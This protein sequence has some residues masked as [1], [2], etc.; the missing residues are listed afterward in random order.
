MTLP[1]KWFI[2][3]APRLAR[4]PYSGVGCEPGVSPV[5]IVARPSRARLALA[6]VN[7]VAAPLD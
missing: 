1:S 4:K 3:M 2:S 6:K 5:L 7:G